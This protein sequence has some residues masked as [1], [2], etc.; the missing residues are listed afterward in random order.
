MPREMEGADLNSLMQQ[1]SF[2]ARV[3]PLPE[4]RPDVVLWSLANYKVVAWLCMRAAEVFE[5]QA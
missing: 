1:K 2:I 3:G 4:T 5:T